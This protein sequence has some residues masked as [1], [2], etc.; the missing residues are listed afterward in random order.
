MER[1]LLIFGQDT[2][3]IERGGE[4]EGGGWKLGSGQALNT[5]SRTSKIS[6]LH[7]KRQP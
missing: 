7:A 6:K 5:G 3:V 4:E 2:R 1:D